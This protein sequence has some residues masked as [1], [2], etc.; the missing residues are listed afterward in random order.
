MN[1]AERAIGHIADP[2]FRAPDTNGRRIAVHHDAVA[3]RGQFSGRAVDRSFQQSKDTFRLGRVFSGVE[4]IVDDVE[5][6]AC[7]QIEHRAVDGLDF[8]PG[9]LPGR[10]DIADIDLLALAQGPQQCVLDGD[11]DAFD[12]RDGSGD[13]LWGDIGCARTVEGKYADRD[14]HNEL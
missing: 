11:C 5:R 13:V 9:V 6:R 10:Q 1:D 4:R 14:N 3:K 7:A 12:A 8:E 2:E